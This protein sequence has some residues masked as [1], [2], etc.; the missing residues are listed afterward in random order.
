MKKLIA[1]IL[2]LVMLVPAVQASVD[3]IKVAEIPLDATLEYT[4]TETNTTDWFTYHYVTPDLW[5]YSCGPED[6]LAKSSIP[7]EGVTHRGIGEV[8]INVSIDVVYNCGVIFNYINESCYDW[9]GVYTLGGNPR[10]G[11]MRYKEW[12]S[13]VM[14][15]NTSD[16]D[17]DTVNVSNLWCVYKVI[18]NPYVGH[19]L[20]KC[21]ETLDYEPN[22]W[23]LNVT[24]ASLVTTS[25]VQWGL[26]C[27]A[28]SP[29]TDYFDFWGVTF[30][31]LYYDTRTIGNDKIPVI[32]APNIDTTLS[33]IDP[34]DPANFTEAV[35]TWNKMDQQSF[36]SDKLSSI[37]YP[38]EN[39]YIFTIWNYTIDK[40]GFLIYQ[41]NDD[42]NSSFDWIS[43]VFDVDHDHLLT[44]GDMWFY[45]DKTNPV[46]ILESYQLDSDGTTWN[47]VSVGGSGMWDFGQDGLTRFN[48]TMW[49]ITFDA[50]AVCPGG[51][52]DA[53]ILSGDY[54]GLAIYGD[55]PYWCWNNWDETTNTNSTTYGLAT[56]RAF[57]DTN[58]EYDT[59]D[60]ADDDLSY[61]GD[62]RFIG[63]TIEEEEP[64]F[65]D[66][67]DLSATSTDYGYSYS[68]FIWHVNRYALSCE[69]LADDNITKIKV[70]STVIR[71]FFFGWFDKTV[72]VTSVI[73]YGVSI[74]DYSKVVLTADAGK[75]GNYTIDEEDLATYDVLVVVLNPSF[76]DTNKYLF[77]WLY[78]SD[79]A[80]AV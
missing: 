79:I 59:P 28:G 55:M 69:K 67:T 41:G 4:W 11:V 63:I 22:T 7:E 47:S 66:L 49:L 42:Q 36:L 74:A 45:L 64:D 24:N 16:I 17:L 32:N 51:D 34:S 1:V 48:H 27:Q 46:G 43:L 18:Y 78:D 61:F 30:C 39:T 2:M 44:P 19:V 20:F 73:F 38:I 6:V 29:P 50:S 53:F 23:D 14:Y 68:S 60:P 65:V 8:R 5:V 37:G 35:A 80:T 58:E 3:T 33:A 12:T 62:F 56:A 71:Q 21:W 10:F 75:N 9:A 70:P 15:A 72:A 40:L 26:Y 13:D 57:N 25:T 77:K 54:L 76:L 52:L 31:S